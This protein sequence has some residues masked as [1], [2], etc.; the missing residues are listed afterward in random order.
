MLAPK[1]ATSG[2]LD[3]WVRRQSHNGLLKQVV[4]SVSFKKKTCHF[5]ECTQQVLSFP[6]IA[7]HCGHLSVCKVLILLF[8]QICF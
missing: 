5:C 7:K 2:Q 1:S 4:I 8:E 6:L 3:G